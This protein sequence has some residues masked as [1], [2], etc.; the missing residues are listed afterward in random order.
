[1]S[2]LNYTTQVDALKTMGEI[3]RILVDHHATEVTKKY[4]D[5]LAI[6]LEFTVKSNGRELP[7]RLPADADA[8]LRVM[9]REHPG[10]SLVNRAQAYRVAWRHILR[11][12]EAQMAFLDTGQVSMAQLFL[13]YAVTSSGKTIFQVVMD[14]GSHLLTPGEQKDA[15]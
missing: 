5:G 14:G 8:V 10:S 6:A 11:W 4:N 3:E 2:L 1:V 12:V 15:G 9:D 7:V 13:P